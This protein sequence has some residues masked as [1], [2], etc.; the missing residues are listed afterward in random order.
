[1]PYICLAR[2]DLPNGTVQVVDLTPNSSQ[3]SEPYD[4]PG[5][6][7]YVNR[8][9]NNPVYFTAAGVTTRDERAFAPPCRAVANLVV[10]ARAAGPVVA[11]VPTAISAVAARNTSAIIV[12]G[13][14]VRV[15]IRVTIAISVSVNVSITIDISI[16]V[17]ITRRGIVDAR[18]VAF[19]ETSLTPREE[20]ETKNDHKRNEH[21]EPVES[22]LTHL[23]PHQNVT[24]APSPISPEPAVS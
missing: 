1:M 9:Q 12:V 16:R 13:I 8:V 24:R 18:S 20:D 19:P 2:A 10:A 11:T 4:P 17:A 5:Q 7:R 14:D 22:T 21:V 6:T 15:A 3:R 23:I